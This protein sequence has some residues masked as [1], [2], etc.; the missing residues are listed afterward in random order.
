MNATAEAEASALSGYGDV[1][2]TEYT[3][4]KPR[5][6]QAGTVNS[7]LRQARPEAAGET[8]PAPRA[9]T[10][11]ARPATSPSR[12]G[13]GRPGRV[14]SRGRAIGVGAR[15]TGRSSRSWAGTPVAPGR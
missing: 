5:Y 13:R 3:N 9:A 15:E 2:H 14:S 8:I 12:R 6:S 4:R 1:I 11:R 10:G 7:S